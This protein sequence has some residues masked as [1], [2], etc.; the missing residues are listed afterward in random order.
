LI[1]SLQNKKG[2]L[3]PSLLYLG[4]ELCFQLHDMMCDIIVTGEKLD[5]F[6]TE[7]NIDAEEVDDFINYLVENSLFNELSKI[8]KSTIFPA[9]LSEI[10]HCIYEALESSRKGK[11][12][13]SYMLVRK[14]IQENLYLFEKIIN[15]ETL[16]TESLCFEPQKLDRG[17]SGGLEQYIKLTSNVL[18][19]V[20][21]LGC[22]NA[23]Y[24]STL[25]Y[26][27]NSLDTFDG[28]CNQSMHLFTSKGLIRTEKMNIN[29]I[30]SNY[31]SKLTQWQY[32]YSRLPYLLFYMYHICEF[33]LS[34]FIFTMPE[35][36]NEMKRRNSALIILWWN[37]LDEMYK[38]D[39]L[40]VF[41]KGNEAW[42]YEHC[43]ENG[44]NIPNEKDLYKM[45]QKG[46]FPSESDKS[47]EKRH[48]TYNAFMEKNQK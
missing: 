12:N 35:Y 5:Y 28:I 36:L 1:S 9:A 16:F 29:F 23:E 7:L 24:I 32:L 10:L 2:T 11:L 15:N 43:I 33:I 38:S 18:D 13:V 47:I 31:K 40:E 17:S 19:K 34:S 26:D 44:Y 45:Y 20:D 21:S 6:K 22:L 25:R 3:L 42:L 48:E 30:F 41:F 14:P 39:E 4:H 37:S 8:L 27:K 46:S